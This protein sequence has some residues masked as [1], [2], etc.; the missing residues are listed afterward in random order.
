LVRSASDGCCGIL[1]TPIRPHGDLQ[2]PDFVEAGNAIVISRT[3]RQSL[4]LRKRCRS[5]SSSVKA[6]AQTVIQCINN[7]TLDAT[8]ALMKHHRTG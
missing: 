7:S 6:G 4:L 3:A 1:P 5:C 2:N 8:N